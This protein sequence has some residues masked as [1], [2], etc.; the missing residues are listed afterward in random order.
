VE[1][2][3]GNYQNLEV[4]KLAHQ[5]TIEVYKALKIFPEDEK[6]NI[7]SQIKRATVSIPT[8]IAEGYGK[9]TTSEF[10]RFCQIAK[11]SA[12]EVEYLLLLSKDLGY[13]EH[14]KYISLNKKCQAILMMLSGLLKAL[15]DK[16]K[17]Q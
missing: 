3:M 13:L 4:W 11:G 6:Y 7:T 10:I 9:H 2:K 8:N 14:E 16:N 1:E 5:F 17:K 15:K 12:V